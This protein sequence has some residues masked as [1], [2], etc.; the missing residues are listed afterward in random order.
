M[1]ARHGKNAYVSVA[2]TDLSAFCD[3]LEL[4]IDGETADTSGFGLTWRTKLPGLLGATGTLSGNYDPTA[5]TGPAA[6]LIAAITGGAS[7]AVVHRPGG[8]LTGQAQR[9]FSANITNYTESSNLEDAVKFASTFE[10]TG[11]V[12]ASIQ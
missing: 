9:S 2:A 7:V 11:A 4:S 6:V 12:T 5:S 3:E 8:T 1:A 10:V